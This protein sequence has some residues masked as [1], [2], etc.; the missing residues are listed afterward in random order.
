MFFFNPHKSHHPSIP[1]P[2]AF[3]TF[4]PH[5]T[6]SLNSCWDGDK[7]TITNIRITLTYLTYL[8]WV[9]VGPNF[10]FKARLLIPIKYNNKN[11]MNY[12]NK[13][14]MQP[15]KSNSNMEEINCI[16]IVAHVFG[17]NTFYMF[18]G[19]PYKETVRQWSAQHSGSSLTI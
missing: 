8:S 15:K 13:S 11:K 5:H 4:L 1:F 17:I 2:L 19:M 12:N 9:K 14:G 18:Y 3:L 16:V 6:S 7:T 10:S